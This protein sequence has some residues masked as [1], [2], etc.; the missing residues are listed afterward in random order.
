LNFLLHLWLARLCHKQLNHDVISCKSF[1]IHWQMDE[2]ILESLREHVAIAEAISSHLHDLIVSLRDT[3]GL[4]WSNIQTYGPIDDH[5]DVFLS[6]IQ[7]IFE[8]CSYRSSEKGPQ[9]DGRI[10]RNAREHFLNISNML[11]IYRVSS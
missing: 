9:R 7:L 1:N 8:M 10:S 2:R 4:I 6:L 3:S 11:F 5:W